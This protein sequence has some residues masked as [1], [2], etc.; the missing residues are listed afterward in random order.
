MHP[1]VLGALG[2]L[3]LSTWLFFDILTLNSATSATCT[4]SDVSQF[5]W[6]LS[7][8]SVAIRSGLNPFF[9]H[10]MF[11]PDGINLLANT[12]VTGLGFPM[13]PI[14]WLLGA[15]RSFLVA[16][17]LTPVAS[18]AA[19]MWLARKYVS[20]NWLAFLAGALYAFSPMVLFHEA[21]GHLNVTFLAVP[22]LLV[23]LVGDLLGN[24]SVR[25]RR[26]AWAIALLLTWQFFIGS[27]VFAMIVL[28]GTISL[29]VLAVGLL[30]VD[31]SAL[32]AVATRCWR[33]AVL[34]LV[35]TSVLL[36][37]PIYEAT[38]GP[39]HYSG[40]VWPGVTLSNATWRDFLLSGHG[41]GLWFAHSNNAFLLATY[42][43]PGLVCTLLAGLI[44]LRRDRRY[45]SLCVL[46]GVM[47]ALSL[48]QRYVI[49][50][51]H[52]L[53]KL[54]VLN[55]IVNERFSAFTMLFCALALV[56][57]VERLLA[58]STRSIGVAIAS[59]ALLASCVPYAQSAWA[60]APYPAST[61]WV[62]AWYQAHA[63]HLEANSVILGFPFFNTSANLLGVQA[64]YH[65]SYSIVGGTT[66]QWLPA[67]QG[68]AAPGYLVIWRLASTRRA[69]N[70]PEYASARQRREV[71]SALS[72]WHVNYVVVPQTNGPNTS[73]VARDPFFVARFL[74]SILGPTT[75]TNGAW[76]WHLTR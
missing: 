73:S 48:G 38:L 35:V 2:Y 29:A 26:T 36:A 45:V 64:K 40:A 54:P 75:V 23:G 30:I 53:V 51:W 55:N 13:I 5:T 15:Q 6:F 72:Y 43:A 37:W 49:A 61:L 22:A 71:L 68:Q 56:V 4:C 18:G 7:W 1:V 25:P 76:V 21:L 59:V 27:E 3:A 46:A 50:P 14:E 31:K 34:V 69:P 19:M 57:I 44:W 8:P 63:T 9:S 10:A 32:I 67:R 62:P 58:L 17:L 41:P 42:L 24:K 47:A 52:Y 66:P 60:N 20:R 33:E 65:M 74:S 16:S 28:A 12:S 39:M 11:H 70:F